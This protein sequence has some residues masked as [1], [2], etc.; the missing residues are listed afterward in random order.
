MVPGLYLYVVF[1]IAFF[2]F[3]VNVRIPFCFSLCEKH[4]RLADNK[5][6]TE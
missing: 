2:Y 6:L 5:F 1:I 3:V 4:V